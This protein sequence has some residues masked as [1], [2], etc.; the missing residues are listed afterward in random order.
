MAESDESVDI[1]SLVRFAEV[2]NVAAPVLTAKL[3]IVPPGAAAFG[4]CRALGMAA[5]REPGESESDHKIR[6]AQR[7][8]RALHDAAGSSG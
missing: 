1:M 7:L 3:V 5:V 4:D 6:L 2:P 8:L